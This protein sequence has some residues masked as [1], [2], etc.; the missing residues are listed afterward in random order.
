M[1]D[2]SGRVWEERESHEA[3]SQ[4]MAAQHTETHRVQAQYIIFY[5]TCA[6]SE[7]Q[8]QHQCLL[9]SPLCIKSF[10]THCTKAK[11]SNEK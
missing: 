10:K 11:I 7:I 6:C 8:Q 9:I 3:L 4:R 1:F 5:G 2:S